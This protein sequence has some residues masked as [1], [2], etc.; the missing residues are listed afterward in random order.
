LLPLHRVAHAD[1]ACKP[2][3]MPRW[4]SLAWLPVALATACEAPSEHG[5]I[6]EEYL[7]EERTRLIQ[8]CQ[9]LVH[10]AW[11]SDPP[12]ATVLHSA[13]ACEALAREGKLEDAR[14]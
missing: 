9:G 13:R 3:S 12:N 2:R 10:E 11:N 7:A 14:A 4:S 5:A 1:T 8:C 6:E